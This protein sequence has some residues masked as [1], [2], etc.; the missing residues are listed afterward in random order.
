[1][2]FVVKIHNR[3]YSSWSLVPAEVQDLDNVSSTADTINQKMIS[4]AELKLFHGDHIEKCTQNNQ[5]GS[6]IQK[7]HCSWV[8]TVA[9]IPGVLVLN[10]STY[11]RCKSSNRFLYK[12][13]PFDKTLPEF[14]IPYNISR[15]SK[16]TISTH[17]INTYVLFK[18]T[19]WNLKH[20]TGQLH[21]VIGPV[22]RPDSYYTYQLHANNI[23]PVTSKDYR[24]IYKKVTSWDS[25]ID[26]VKKT[27]T[28]VEYDL[29]RCITV[30]PENSVDFDD[31]IG[32]NTLPNNNWVVFIYIANVPAWVKALNYW[33]N[34]KHRC[35]TIYLP[36]K[37]YSMFPSILG[38]DLMSL[39]ANKQR[40]AV[41]MKIEIN[42]NDISNIV[43]VTID[44]VI[45]TVS[46][47]YTYD[48]PDL[49]KDITYKLLNKITLACNAVTNYMDVI[50]DSHAVVAYWM[51]CMN[52]QIGRKLVSINKGIVRCIAG[53][54]T[55]KSCIS[56]I[57]TKDI[58][59]GVVS[60]ASR[61]GCLGG[62]YMLSSENIGH[63]YIGNGLDAYAHSTSPIRRLVDIVNLSRILEHEAKETWGTQGNNA[64]TEIETMLDTIND[65]MRRIRKTTQQC[66]LLHVCSVFD[67][68]NNTVTG[69]CMP[70]YNS[71]ETDTDIPIYI[72]S[73]QLISYVKYAERYTPLSSHKFKILVFQDKSTFHTKVKLQHI[74]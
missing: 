32:C 46:K 45:V 63:T 60:C 74:L 3:D 57:K 16:Q 28:S 30:D 43:D 24:S 33:D 67:N 14:L 22:H 42:P 10:G 11:G 47:N 15:K 29:N 35:S 40:H 73:L 18:F 41:R 8:R 17:K 9:Y 50:N 69:Y 36:K 62:K 7:Y 5:D 27:M 55:V 31:A 19:E 25:P 59:A 56:S 21:E 23:Y 71:C 34:I 20:P 66:C 68:V 53:K 44:P 38:D 52:H 54:D 70:A 72:P 49:P 12:C 1:M 26:H 64:L 2:R 4:P 37:K 58:P 51:T 65:K 39:V 61:W 13:I 6:S 48:D